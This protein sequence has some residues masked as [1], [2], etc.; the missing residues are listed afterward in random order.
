MAS[1]RKRSSIRGENDAAAI[2]M[3][4]K[5]QAQVVDYKN[6]PLYQVDHSANASGRRFGATKRH[7]TFH[8][9]FAN[10]TYAGK[11]GVEC[12][13]KEHNVELMWSLATGKRVV[14]LDSH[15]I[16]SSIVKPSTH[17]SLFD[18]K[19]EY[20]FPLDMARVAVGSGSM[21]GGVIPSRQK[22]RQHEANEFQGQSEGRM[23]KIVAHPFMP[24]GL[25]GITTPHCQFD[26]TIDG[27]SYFEFAKMYEL[28]K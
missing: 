10:L 1:Q 24:I 22:G 6:A 15:V 23:C 17:S 9:G 5:D 14:K 18:S 20:L 25:D 11:T 2:A 27:Q 4:Q 8:F 26:F 16:H 3:Q 13:G 28:G 12:R 7:V 21:N 19:F